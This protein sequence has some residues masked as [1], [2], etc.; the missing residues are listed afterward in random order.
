[1]QRFVEDPLSEQ[2][3][4]RKVREGDTV[5][6]SKKGD[7]LAFEAVTPKVKE[8]EEESEVHQ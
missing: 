8:S 4:A 1:V 7:T 6:V 5:K 3:L 2:F